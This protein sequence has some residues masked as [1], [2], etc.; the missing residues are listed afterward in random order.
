MVIAEL[1][2]EFETARSL[3]TRSS[4]IRAALFHHFRHTA[5]NWGNGGMTELGMVLEMELVQGAERNSTAATL[6]ELAQK[7]SCLAQFGIQGAKYVPR[8]LAR[9]GYIDIAWSFFTQRNYPGWMHW[10]STGVT[11]LLENWEGSQSWN[12]I[13]FGDFVA[14]AF[15]YLGGVRFTQEFAKGGPLQIAPVIPSALDSFQI[16]CR[17][18][19]GVVKSRWEK[20]NGQLEIELAL[21]QAIEVELSFAKQNF[22]QYGGTKRY[23]F[24][25]NS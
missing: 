18:K 4:R 16:Y 13:M 21:P 3:R 23:I 5:G 22:R 8:A 12:H 15:E 17:T 2:G 14:F 1:L 7:N 6:A 25:I 24:P 20:R 10:L 11:T 9:N 19:R